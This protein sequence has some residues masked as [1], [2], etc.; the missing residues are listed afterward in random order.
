L[1]GKRLTEMRK[2]AGLTQVALAKKLGIPRST[3]SNYENGKREPDLK[4]LQNIASFF[5]VSTDF[6]LG[7]T[8]DPKKS[9][10]TEV[11]IDFVN[12]PNIRPKYKGKELTPQEIKKV[13]KMLEVILERMDDESKTNQNQT[14]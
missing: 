7:H 12:N 6:L 2:K 4:T 9:V 10:I 3:Y 13:S 5:E 1:L 8:N 14:P 11:D